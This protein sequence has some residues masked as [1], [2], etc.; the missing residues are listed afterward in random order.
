[1]KTPSLALINSIGFT[2]YAQ[3]ALFAASILKAATISSPAVQIS[4]PITAVAGKRAVA[5]YAGFP[6]STAQTA[7]QNTAGKLEGQVFPGRPAIAAIAASGGYAAVAAVSAIA[8]SPAFLAGTAIPAYPAITPRAAVVESVPVIAKSAVIAPAITAING[9]SDAV[10]IEEI[11]NGVLELTVYLP[12]ASAPALIGSTVEKILEIT[13][14]NS[15]PLIWIGTKASNTPT[16]VTTVPET[17]EEYFLVNATNAIDSSFQAGT[18]TTEN[19]SLGGVI[20][21]CT[22]VILK[23][24]RDGSF[25]A[26][27]KDIQLDTVGYYEMPLIDP[28]N[29]SMPPTPGA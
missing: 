12:I 24:Q 13:P 16:A 18:I 2:N 11:G 23:L 14:A 4:A 1:M 17:L 15:T 19:Y 5:G 26:A 8:P 27:N 28:G 29:G 10:K 20:K 7:V 6:G 21:S 22:K 3:K 9:Y 25:N